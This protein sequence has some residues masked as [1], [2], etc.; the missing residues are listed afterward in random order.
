MGSSYSHLPSDTTKKSLY[1]RVQDKKR[2]PGP[3]DEDILKYTGK[4]RQ[5]LNAWA[6]NQPGVG[7]NQ[8]AGTLTV[9]PASGFGGLAIGGGYGGW[10]FDGHRGLKFAPVKNGGDKGN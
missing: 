6:E 10:G 7:K 5:Q 4:T 9:G 3:G 2:G 8:L 1:Q